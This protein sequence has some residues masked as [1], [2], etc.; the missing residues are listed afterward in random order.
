MTT[1]THF[2][3]DLSKSALLVMDAQN[4][5]VSRLAPDSDAL[6]TTLATA[7]GA[8]REA[9]IPVIY[10]RLSFRDGAPEISRRNKI[11]APIATSMGGD[12]EG[13]QICAAIA[14]QNGDVVVIKKRVGAFAGSDLAV[15][16]S[17]LEVST[18]VL[19]GVATSGVVLSTL[20]HAADLDYQLI[21]LR[22]GCADADEEVHRVLLDKVFPRQADVM[23]SAEWIERL[24]G[25]TPSAM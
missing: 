13:R 14:P 11:F 5:T 2:V 7:I 18:L 25:R 4:Q 3:Q 10:V 22:D 24:A 23:T 20:R 19:T 21:V 6:V 1:G 17:A 16:L 12:A 9:G 8:A 15:V